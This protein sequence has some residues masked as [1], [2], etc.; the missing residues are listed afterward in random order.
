M[1]Y[2]KFFGGTLLL[3]TIIILGF[4]TNALAAD[5][6]CDGVYVDD[7]NIGGQTKQKAEKILK[8]YL[9]SLEKKVVKVKTNDRT[10]KISL[11]D[12]GFVT[13]NDDSVNRALNV[14]GVGNLIQRY[15]DILDAKNGHKVFKS[16][17]AYDEG[18]LKKFVDNDCKKCDHGIIEPTFDT[19]GKI[20]NKKT[21]SGVKIKK[22]RSGQVVD[23]NDALEKIKKALENWNKKD[24]TVTAKVKLE[25]P[26]HSEKELEACNRRLGTFTTYFSGGDGNRNQNIR[27]A[28]GLANGSILYPGETFSLLSKIMPFTYDNGYAAAGSYSNGQVVPAMGGG[29]C[30]V[31]T[32]LY[33]AVLRAEQQIVQRNC[34]SMTV[35]YV[36]LSQDAMLAEGCSDF[37]FKNTTKAPLYI[38]GFAGGGSITFNVYG[39]ETRNPKR[40]ISFQTEGVFHSG[41]GTGA[42]LYK[43]VYMNGKQVDR[44]FI[45]SSF[46]K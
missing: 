11:K 14:G 19:K 13:I 20:I 12:I 22:G 8:K 15:K 31:S 5:K 18:L 21:L 30:Q 23:K 35:H 28:A 29:V 25:K 26:K 42:S 32:T 38:E 7:V 17:F 24:I 43:Y 44:I 37:Q 10:A 16:G 36:P 33:G 27:R 2:F 41:A 4:A 34:H 39:K 40:K 46:Y 1:K 6:V 45:N 3:S 9:A